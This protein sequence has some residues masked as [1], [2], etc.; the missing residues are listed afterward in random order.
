[1]H[2]TIKPVARVEFLNVTEGR[3]FF[4]FF[5]DNAYAGSSVPASLSCVQIVMHVKDC[6]SFSE[7]MY[8]GWW[9]GGTQ[10]MYYLI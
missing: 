2:W 3:M 7:R 8:D 5:P 9:H 4:Q 6:P 10:I 1:M